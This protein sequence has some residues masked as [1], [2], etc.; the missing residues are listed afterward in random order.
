MTRLERALHGIPRRPLGV[1]LLALLAAN[2]AAWLGALAL[3]TLQAGVVG[4][5]GLAWVLGARHAFDV[6]HIAAIDNVTRKLRH[7]GDRP[8]A[9][10][11][12]FALGHSSVVV[13]L[14]ALI[15]LG[16]RGL[17]P[18]FGELSDFGGFF[19]TGVSAAF[20]TFIGL[21]NILVLRQ[22]LRAASAQRRACAAPAEEEHVGALLQQRGLFARAFSFL[23]RRVSR[24]W[25]MYPIGVLF[26]LGFDTATEIAILGIS[27]GLATNAAF[28][29]WGILVFALL[30][31]AGMT[32]VDS[33]DGVLMLRAYHWAADDLR[34]R[35]RFNTIITAMAA[36][37][38]TVI[39]S[40][41]W[42][43]LLASRLRGAGAL[44]AWLERLDYGVLGIAAV[45]AMLAA[46]RG[47]GPRG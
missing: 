30:F 22:L 11:F 14:C 31:T 34:R 7:E 44:R 29:L 5:A 46:A 47:A 23:L 36:G 10:G 33:L 27:A 8:V 32:L 42:V 19:G 20:L 6:D 35:L 1:L 18:R 3:A 39:G 40:L 24:S 17:A 12:F 21:T 13:A 25:H 28:P 16:A 26:G 38:A 43:E 2:A 9:V 45:A 4:L 41:E 15:A 37:L